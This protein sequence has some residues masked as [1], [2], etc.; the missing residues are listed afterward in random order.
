MLKLPSDHSS[1]LQTY[2][3]FTRTQHT[4]AGCTLNGPASLEVKMEGAGRVSA[5]TAPLQPALTPSQ[6]IHTLVLPHRVTVPG[7]LI[8]SFR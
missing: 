6:G 3:L 7:T 1:H 4:V 8:H 5:P 2:L